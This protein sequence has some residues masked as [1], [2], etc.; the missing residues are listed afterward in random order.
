MHRCASYTQRIVALS[1]FACSFT[2]FQP[3]LT[4]AQ[5]APGLQRSPNMKL[6]AHIPLGGAAPTKP[7][8]GG[9]IMGLGRRT[10]DIDIEQELSRPYAYVTHRFAPSGFHVVSLADPN[11][12]KVIYHWLI[13]N[14][15]LH[16]GS[17]ALNPMYFKLNGR[18]YLTVAFQFQ[19][20]G[21]DNDLGAIVFDVT[22]LPNPA[23]VKEVARIRLPETP[24]GFHESFTYKHSDG[25]VLLVATTGS[26]FAHAYDM[27]KVVAGVAPAQAL[28][29]RIPV[30][31]GASGREVR[32][33]YHDF[34]IGYDPSDNKDK[35]YGAG[36]GGYH[37]YDITDLNAPKLLTSVTGVS[38]VGGGHTFTPTPDGRYAVGETE[39]R[40]SPL[41]IY[42]LKS[43]PGGTYV[44]NVNRPIGAW[45]ANW[46]NFAH[47]HEVRWPYVFVAAFD[48][49]LQ[50]MNLMDPTNPITVG[51]YDSWDGPDG[52]LAKPETT[53]NGAW[54]V[55]VRNADGLIV[56]S[57]FTTGFWAFKMEGFDGWNG[58]D[59]GM[60]NVSS[61]QDYDNGPE[62]TPKAKPVT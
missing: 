40:H 16:Q 19:Q 61:A 54:G 33:A 53:F 35:F 23:A 3:C 7:G 20:G 41:R 44:P 25:K 21:P 30:P 37:V 9:D 24:G 46:K 2:A 47:N 57:D 51:Y 1:L 43:G 8:A 4:S 50:V 60:P 48:D 55:D 12:P 62:G 22:G 27:A 52:T 26:P 28:A 49:G 6:V 58:K 32:R 42:D 29:G 5:H 31:E 11:K 36:A 17:G 38:G 18:Y 15:E 39:Y 14:P 45:T 56:I 59:W 13:D 10:S 34:Y